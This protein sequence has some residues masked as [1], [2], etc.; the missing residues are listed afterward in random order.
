MILN[1]KKNIVFENQVYELF[2]MCQH[3]GSSIDSKTQLNQGSIA[4]ISI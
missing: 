1:P 4:T 3:C 2:E